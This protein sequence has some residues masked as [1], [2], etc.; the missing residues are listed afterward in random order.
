MTHYAVSVGDREYKVEVQDSG[1]L[2]NS[3][4]V[5]FELTSLND[6]G[7]HLFDGG[8]QRLRGAGGRSVPGGPR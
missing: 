6:N 7:L 1:L 5:A 2:V 4:P 3:E 8:S